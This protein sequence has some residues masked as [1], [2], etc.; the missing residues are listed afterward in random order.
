[1]SYEPKLLNGA[2]VHLV[3]HINLSKPYR[4]NLFERLRPDIVDDLMPTDN[5]D[6]ETEKESKTAQTI[7]HQGKGQTLRL[8]VCWLG[9]LDLGHSWQPMSALVLASRQMHDIL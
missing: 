7:N 1:M 8:L 9:L 2:K 3:F 6:K 4:N 5:K